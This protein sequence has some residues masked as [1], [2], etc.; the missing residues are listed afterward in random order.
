MR[1]A[2]ALL[3]ISYAMLV[4]LLVVGNK[5]LAHLRIRLVGGFT[6]GDV[7]IVLFI[8]FYGLVIYMTGLW[9]VRVTCKNRHRDS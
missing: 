1:R 5:A 2:L 7:V 6:V 9:A 3:L 8:F 4:A